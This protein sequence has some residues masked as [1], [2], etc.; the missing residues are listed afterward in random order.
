LPGFYLLEM[1]ALSCLAAVLA[2]RDGR[3]ARLAPWTIVGAIAGFVVVGAWSLGP[4]YAPALLLLGI[5]AALAPNASGRSILSGL[6]LAAVA[7]AAQAA[8]MLS[9][10]RVVDPSA[11]F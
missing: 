10:V 9:L 7:G 4:A 1:V 11:S 2:F 6:A 3:V 8:I 5:S